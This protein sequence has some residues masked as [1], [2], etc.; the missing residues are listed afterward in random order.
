MAGARQ[1]DTEA[2]EA[3]I[4]R[5]FWKHGFA[6][7]SIEAIEAETGLRRGS[8]YNAFGDKKAMFALA[9]RRYAGAARERVFAA[10]GAA[11]PE[12]GVAALFASQLAALSDPALPRG[13]LVTEALAGCEAMPPEAADAV[14]AVAEMQHA[15]LA[16]ALRRWQEAGQLDAGADIDGLA[17]LLAAALYGVAARF[18]LTGDVAA[19]RAAG[20]A[21]VRALAAFRPG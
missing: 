12:E 6:A 10:L 15:T 11:T 16:A 5:A 17:R 19:A 2:A 13:C 14:A 8:L 20:A 7:T 18:R 3:G 21:A 1:F 9:L 4:T